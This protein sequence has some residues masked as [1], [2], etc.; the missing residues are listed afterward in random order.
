MFFLCEARGGMRMLNVNKLIAS[1]ES[2]LGWPYVSP[3]TN[4]QNGIDCS[5]LFVKCYRDQKANIYHGS[6]TIFH[7]YCSRTGKL[8]SVSQLQ[9]G[10]AVFKIKD[11]TDADKGNKWYG[12]EPGNLSHIGLVVSVNPLRIIHAS[13]VAGCVTTDTSIGKWK[14]YGMLKDVAY[15]NSDPAPVQPSKDN[16]E[17]GGV[18]MKATV[19]S[20]N[21]QPVNMR[22]TPNKA[23]RLITKIAVGET[24]DVNMEG[25]E[26]TLI[27]YKGQTGYMMTTFLH[28]DNDGYDDGNDMIMVERSVLQDIYD[29]ID[30]LL[31]G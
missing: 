18:I 5:G 20:A 3:G 29:K 22:A 28:F 19:T 9:P 12:K 30:M 31:H 24:V 16:N 7:D 13:S 26:W 1:A 23:G 8:T 11:W 2:C 4:D 6:N 25:N 27:S 14:Y 10:M 17:T 21:G 15:G